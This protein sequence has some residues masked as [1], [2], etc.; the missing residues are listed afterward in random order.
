MHVL[1]GWKCH[2]NK[3]KQGKRTLSA[4][5]AKGI[6]KLRPPQLDHLNLIHQGLMQ[7]NAKNRGKMHFWP[8]VLKD[9]FKLRPPQLDTLMD[10]NC[11]KGKKQGKNAFLATRAKPF[12]LA[13]N[14]AF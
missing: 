13:N 6:S 4:A 12:F 7:K 9:F 3:Q 14:L 5:N 1:M 10:G 11:K 8:P 2:K